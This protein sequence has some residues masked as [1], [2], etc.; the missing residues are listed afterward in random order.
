M[1]EWLMAIC[2]MLYFISLFNEFKELDT[3]ACVKDKNSR[4]RG[5]GNGEGVVDLN[6]Y[7]S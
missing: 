1:S 3:G 7:A 6:A 4:G 5:D 2:L